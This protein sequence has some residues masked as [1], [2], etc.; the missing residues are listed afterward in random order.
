MALA[1]A[2]N[3]FVKYDSWDQIIAIE[4]PT[5]S[6]HVRLGYKKS[7]LSLPIFRVCDKEGP[8][9]KLQKSTTFARQLAELGH[10]T[11][12]TE[13]ITIHCMRREILLKVDGK[14]DGRTSAL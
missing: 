4:K 3:V 5:C 9:D 14:F 13:N 1:L 7:S 11:G 6:Q 2:D 8:T 10:R 12:L